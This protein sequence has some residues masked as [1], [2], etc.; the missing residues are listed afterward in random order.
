MRKEH[1]RKTIALIILTILCVIVNIANSR[2]T[3]MP[4]QGNIMVEISG[5]V[6]SFNLRGVL[7]V[8]S[9]IFCIFMVCIDCKR[10]MILT[11]FILGVSIAAMTV[12]SV[13]TRS[14]ESLPGAVT[15]VLMMVA[16]IVIS[17]SMKKIE[18][19]SVTDLVTNLYNRRGLIK[20]LQ[21]RDLN[22]KYYMMFLRIRNLKTVND[23]LGYE[24]GDTALR[25]LSER[26]KKAAGPESLVSKLDGTEFAI[27]IP[28]K[29]DIHAKAKAIM[30]SV[31]QV[32]ELEADGNKANFYLSACAG[33][34]SY[35]DDAKSTMQLLKYADMA[36]YHASDKTDEKIIFFSENL[37]NEIVRRANVENLIKESL[38]ND[39]FYLVYQPQ[40][41]SYNKQ[42]RGFE[43][44]I[45]MKCP[46][47][48]TV[49][50]GEFIPIAE[51][52]D[53]IFEIDDYVLR[54]ALSEFKDLVK[55]PRGDIT[56]SVNVS[57]R[58]ISNP[59]F[60]QKLNRIIEETGFPPECLEIEITEYSL[61]DS[62]NQTVAN[63]NKIKETGIKLALDDFGT[64]YTSLSQLLNLPFDLLKIDKSLVDTIEVSEVSRDFV[65]LVIY[66]GHIMKA[67]VISEGVETETQLGLLKDQECDFIQ[68]YVWGRPLSYQ[69]AKELCY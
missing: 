13:V 66:M 35:P 49:S 8:F 39:Y 20:E 63:I 54:R 40:Y 11:W 29:D 28:S 9:A 57:A 26:V 32:V 10:G 31:L 23:N 38:I 36:M 44:L 12:S 43:T 41:C 67:E 53:L 50:P 45:R 34:A 1:R 18:R 16:S 48:T 56:I 52:T 59:G 51:K 62:L 25:I 2:M 5:H 6:T 46:D 3:H 47:G 22:K 27:A 24:Y 14:L 64:G 4:N 33:I 58:D 30:D 68:G 61:Y 55:T 37:E 7:Q 60:P 21:K 19:D 15:L 17:S 65:T 42:L 69:D